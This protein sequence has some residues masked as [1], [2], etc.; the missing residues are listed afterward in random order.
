MPVRSVVAPSNTVA[1]VLDD[2]EIK[3]R[4]KRDVDRLAEEFLRAVGVDIEGKVKAALMRAIE[5]DLFKAPLPA[6]LQR[7]NPTF[8]RAQF[9]NNAGGLATSVEMTAT[10]AGQDL[11]GLVKLFK[12]VAE[13]SP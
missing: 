11:L 6:E 1:F 3:I 5:P 12:P 10:V 4:G 7:L 13:G 9:F 2:P 8:T